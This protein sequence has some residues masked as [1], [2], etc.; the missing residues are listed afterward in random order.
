MNRVKAILAA[1]MAIGLAGC[2]LRGKQQ[3]AKAAP[4]PKPALAPAAA[5]TPEPLSIPQ[6]RVELPPP[7]PVSPGALPAA[8]AP[9]EGP[10]E[11]PPG[12]PRPA[13]APSRVLVPQP[14]PETAPPAAPPAPAEPERPQIQEILPASEQKR[15]QESADA[16]KMEVELRIEQVKHRRM[17]SR[18]KT[19][20]SSIESFLKLSNQAEARGDMRQA[21]ELALRA[22]VLARELQ[23]GQ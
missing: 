21:D 2:V 18:E 1:S 20:V 9:A 8:T 17:T 15:L 12:S 4:P 16:R 7:Q 22:L 11:A 14:K 23:R 6:T 13:R 10:P 3:S 5:P 19:I